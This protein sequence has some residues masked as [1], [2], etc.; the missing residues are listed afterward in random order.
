[1]KL[2]R[3]PYVSAAPHTPPA[4]SFMVAKT[5]RSSCRHA[6]GLLPAVVVGGRRQWAPP[7]R[8]LLRL[9]AGLTLVVTSCATPVRVARVDPL[10]VERQLDSNVLST[11]HLSE[12]T[13]IVLYRAHLGERF[14]TDPDGALASL[15]RTLAAAPADPGV[16]FALA[17]MSF[18]K[19]L[20]TGQQPQALTVAVYAYAFLFPQD[21]HHRPSGFDPRMR[22]ACDIYNRSLTRAF[23][24]A[25]H[26]R[27]DLQ[28]GRYALSFGSLDVTFDP[29]SA[30]WGDQ[31]LSHFTSTDELRITGLQMR[32]R[33][34][35]LGA[36]LA[37]PPMPPPRGTKT[38]STSN[39]MSRCR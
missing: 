14:A 13:R 35:G 10:E 8:T 12:A 21:P 25:D 30:R 38:I 4:A 28:A 1:M 16:L 36:A 39:R 11:Q 26:A 9:A 23:A 2:A 34:P 18:L 6:A 19:A 29:A 20:R 27:I 32:Y 31:L 24:S 7:W 17:E 3:A 5:L 37:A 15:H 33:R 22:T